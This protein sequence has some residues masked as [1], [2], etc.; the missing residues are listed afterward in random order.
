MHSETRHEFSWDGL[1][2]DEWLDQ[3]VNVLLASSFA[4]R[5]RFWWSECRSDSIKHTGVI[6]LGSTAAVHQLSD[7]SVVG[8]YNDMRRRHGSCLAASNLVEDVLHQHDLYVAREHVYHGHGREFHGPLRVPPLQL[9]NCLSE[10][11]PDVK[12]LLAAADV[13]FKSDKEQSAAVR[14]FVIQHMRQHAQLFALA[15]CMGSHARLGAESPLRL[16]SGDALRHVIMPLLEAQW[17]WEP[18]LERFQ[19]REP[20]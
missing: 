20:A 10:V 3:R 6:F 7:L 9:V 14:D 16:L 18:P 11:G 4:K 15:V 13:G 19:A 17:D 8:M 1:W 2:V 5:R 12:A